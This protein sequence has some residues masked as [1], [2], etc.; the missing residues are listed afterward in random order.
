MERIKQLIEEAKAFFAARWPDAGFRPLPPQRHPD[1]GLAGTPPVNPAAHAYQNIF[2]PSHHDEQ[3]TVFRPVPR[4]GIMPKR[5]EVWFRRGQTQHSVI[6][7]SM[8][9]TG[10]GAIVRSDQLK[11]K[12]FCGRYEHIIQH[13]EACNRGLCQIC[14]RKFRTASGREIILCERDLQIAIDGFNTWQRRRHQ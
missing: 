11:V 2:R 7:H 14:A 9:I 5:K 3:Q 1:A 12:C 10:S 8:V 6:Q 13:C 4:D